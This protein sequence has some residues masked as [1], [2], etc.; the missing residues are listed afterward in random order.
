MRRLNTMLWLAR[1]ARLSLAVMALA[2][3]PLFSGCA[4]VAQT[5]QALPQEKAPAYAKL[6]NQSVAVLVW[7]PDGLRTDYDKIVYDTAQLV[8]SK[9]QQAQAGAKPRE[10]SGTTF[11][12]R[13][14]SVVRF[15]EEHP[16][17]AFTSIEDIA[18]RL[19]VSRVIYI[20]IHD[21]QTRSAASQDLFLGT[22]HGSVKVI[23]VADGKGHVAFTDDTLAVSF[24]RLCPPEG[25]PN[26]GDQAVY[27]GTLEGLSSEVVKRFIPHGDDPDADYGYPQIEKGNG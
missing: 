4:L 15:Q 11:P 6:A 24:P 20:E 22:V 16:E 5:L 19:G 21:L 13:A 7:A 1:S 9:L 18:P 27:S 26:L 3:L 2:V 14:A 17:M 10:L 8:Q 23:E 25:L 12:V